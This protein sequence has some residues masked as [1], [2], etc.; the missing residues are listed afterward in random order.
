MRIQIVT[1]FIPHHCVHNKDST[2][3]KLRVVLD[4]S[5][6]ST[7]GNA[8]LGSLMIGQIAQEDIFAVGI[9]LRFHKVSLFPDIAKMYRQVASDEAP[10]DFFSGAI[11][12]QSLC[13]S[14]A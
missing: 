14:I 1:N 3:A 11:P 10:V 12:H 2:T 9:L 5:L 7:T 6:S 4:E 13:C 8:L